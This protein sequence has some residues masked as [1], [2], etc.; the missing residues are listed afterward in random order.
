MKFVFMEFVYAKA[1]IISMRFSRLSMRSKLTVTIIPPVILTLFFVGLAYNRFFSDFAD[2]ALE[3]SYRIQCLAQ[4]DEIEKILER[5][6]IELIFLSQNRTTIKE[7]KAFLERQNQTGGS[8]YRELAYVGLEDSRRFLIWNTGISILEIQPDQWQEI[9]P[10]PMVLFDNIRLL[11]PDQVYVSDICETDYP[12]PQNQNGNSTSSVV[13]RLVVPCRNENGK[14]KGFLS[15]GIDMAYLRN[16]LTLYNSA[17]SPL[18]AF[19]QSPDLRS[20]Y[21]FDMQGW[22]LFQSENMDDPLIPLSAV[23]IRKGVAGIV[24]KPGFENAFLPDDENQVY[25]KMVTAVRAGNHS[26]IRTDQKGMKPGGLGD[27]FSLVYAPIS[28]KSHMGREPEIIFGL[29]YLDRS[30]LIFSEFMQPRYFFL[31]IMISMTIV[32]IVTIHIL[33]T[34]V[35]RPSGMKKCP[36]FEN[37]QSIRAEQKEAEKEKIRSGE[38]SSVF[39]GRNSRAAAMGEAEVIQTGSVFVEE[40]AVPGRTR[41]RSAST[42]RVEGLPLGLSKRQQLIFPFILENGGITRQEYQELLGEGFPTRTAQYD[43]EMMV[44]KNYLKKRGKGQAAHYYPISG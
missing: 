34:S 22:I 36:A 21:L 8:I 28:F 27:C 32:I 43:L 17:K 35:F 7:A 12:F 37:N 1:A 40:K 26:L 39:N 24:G 20:S 16:V 31:M 44:K 25:W 5:C 4:A 29:A 23:R 3:R 18:N 13:I 14:P 41:W 19:P 9:K 11:E 30:R 10:D 42:G 38:E 33:S 6:R 2:V 15:I